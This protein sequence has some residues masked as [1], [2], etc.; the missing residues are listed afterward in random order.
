MRSKLCPPAADGGENTLPQARALV[1]ELYERYADLPEDEL[2][3]R[4]VSALRA[5]A[6]WAESGDFSHALVEPATVTDRPPKAE[7]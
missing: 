1:E 6:R 3:A 2:E 5:R 7:R 4:F